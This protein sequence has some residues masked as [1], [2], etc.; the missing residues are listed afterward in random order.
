MSGSSEGGAGGAPGS[1]PGTAQPPAA[2]G[3][4]A[5]YVPQ[6]ELDKATQRARAEQSRADQA[7]SRYDSLASELSEIKQVMS[8]FDPN[9]IVRQVQAGI[10]QAQ[11]LASEATKLRSE[12]PH[13]RTEIYDGTFASP[14]ELRAAIQASHSSEEARIQQIRDAARAEV[15]GEVKEKH[16]IE[17]AP[18]TPPV[19]D[20]GEKKLTAA[21]VA[22]MSLSE[23]M[24]LP[25]GVLEGLSRGE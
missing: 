1:D 13:A 20:G 18:A 6:S 14:E 8:S 21:D 10:H 22:A 19:N 16:G 12:F 24:R 23:K 17:L 9:S 2:S 4:P 15:L 3:V 5:G 7:A 11:A 25:D